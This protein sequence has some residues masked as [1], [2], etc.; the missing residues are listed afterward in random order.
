MMSET[1]TL[2][3]QDDE[4][5]ARNHQVWYALKEYRAKGWKQLLRQA[6]L[7]GLI[8]YIQYGSSSEDLAERIKTIIE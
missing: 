4:R 3:E 1:Q 2:A 6:A 5:Y 8:S 7:L